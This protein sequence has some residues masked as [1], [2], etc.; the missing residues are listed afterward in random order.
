MLFFLQLF[1]IGVKSMWLINET[2]LR[3]SKILGEKNVP[4]W[5][6]ERKITI[7]KKNLAVDFLICSLRAG[8]MLLFLYSSQ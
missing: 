2:G 6:K 5:K 7:D 8:I 4:S 3:S 1:L